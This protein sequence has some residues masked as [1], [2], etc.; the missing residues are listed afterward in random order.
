MQSQN[1][2]SVI[3]DCDPGHDDAIS[4]I[5]AASKIS[6]LEIEAITTVAG[7][8]DVERNTLNALRVCDIAGLTDVPVAQGSSKPLL[9]K[10]EVAEEIHGETGLEGPALPDE[11][12]KQ[13]VDQ[14]AVDMIIDKVMA[15][16][17]DITLVPTGPLTN[18]ALAM[19]R[20]PAIIPKINKIVLMG[21]GTFGNWTPAA[22][23]NIYVDA[24]AAKIVFES[25]VPIT[26]FGL[27]VTHQALATQETVNRLS[28]IDHPVSHFVVD[29]L[30][31]F[32]RTNQDVFGM[33]GGPIHDACTVAYLIDP[34]IF[35]VH[36]VHVA[37]ETRGEF[38][39][40]MTCV[41]TR[42]VTNRE[43]NVNVAYQLDHHRFWNLFE[44]ALKSYSG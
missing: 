41:D 10:M 31:F 32:I 29:L 3:L 7:N 16:D 8:V 36:Y 26:M 19:I 1:H 28:A 17:G 33:D 24:E 5:L 2:T 43:P 25:G 20:E 42:G 9:K 27:D 12:S 23:F 30:K 34:S 22:E 37:I 38:T 14:H 15:S 18:I 44:K 39:Y 6:P 35:D 21:G 4:I 11:P 13:A 40:G